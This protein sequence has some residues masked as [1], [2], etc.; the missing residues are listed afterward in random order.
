MAF[1]SFRSSPWPM[2]S[3]LR[4]QSGLENGAETAEGSLRIEGV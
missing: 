1:V 2:I 3:L 4:L